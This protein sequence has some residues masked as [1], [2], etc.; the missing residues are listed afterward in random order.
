MFGDRKPIKCK[1]KTVKGMPNWSLKFYAVGNRWCIKLLI[2]H[3]EIIDYTLFYNVHNC[4][5]STFES[6][7]YLFK[8]NNGIEF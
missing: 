8:C 4:D 5:E 6:K 3:D 7:C 1:P 2:D